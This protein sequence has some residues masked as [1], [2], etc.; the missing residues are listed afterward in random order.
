MYQIPR[1]PV[2]P[3]T[4]VWIEMYMGRPIYGTYESLPSREC[5]LKCTL[6]TPA[7]IPH[8]S[9]PSRE[10]GLK[11]QIL[12]NHLT[13]D[14]VTPFTGVWIEIIIRLMYY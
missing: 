3:F 12:G 1:I 2:T 9:L 4:G 11:Y 14:Y 5:G 8:T 7:D 10:C 13:L 6:E